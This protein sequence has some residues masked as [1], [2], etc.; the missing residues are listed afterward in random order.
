MCLDKVAWFLLG[1]FRSLETM[2]AMLVSCEVVKYINSRS[3]LCCLVVVTSHV[4]I[5]SQC[6][7]VIGVQSRLDTSGSLTL[8]SED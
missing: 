6:F 8:L 4:E 3:T 7:A 5:P 2:L 1:Y